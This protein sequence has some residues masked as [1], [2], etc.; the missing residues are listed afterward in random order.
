MN[1]TGKP[2][3]GAAGLP[4]IDVNEYGGKGK[5]G[6]RQAVCDEAT[7]TCSVRSWKC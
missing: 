6:E 5:D 3:S 1:T 4:N 7:K 2:E